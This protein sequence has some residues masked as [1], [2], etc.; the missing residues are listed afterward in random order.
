GLRLNVMHMVVMD[1]VHA[2][3]KPPQDARL[4]VEKVLTQL[5]DQ[6]YVFGDL[7]EP[8]ILFDTDNQVKFIDFDW[9]GWYD[10][11]QADGQIENMNRVQ[12]GDGTYAHYPLTMSKMEGMWAAADMKPLTQIRPKHD[13]AMAEKL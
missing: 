11:G 6:G 3:L 4:Q 13:W 7:R 9:C 10:M 1:Y 8:N 2:K 5:H 12:A